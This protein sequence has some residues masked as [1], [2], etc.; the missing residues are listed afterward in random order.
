MA[1]IP[2]DAQW[3]IADVVLEHT[4][5]DDP[6]NLVW[7]NTILVEANSPENAW[8]NAQQKGRS[9]ESEYRNPDGK[10]VKCVFRGLRALHVIHDKLQDGS[11]L[12]YEQHEGISEDEI[13]ALITSREEL[14]VFAPRQVQENMPNILPERCMKILDELGYTPEDLR[15]ES[16]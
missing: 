4:V 15:K 6:R 2:E 3:Y 12:M 8:Q 16:L 7:V 11:E 5:E 1:Y 10:N 13:Q 14:A 9:A